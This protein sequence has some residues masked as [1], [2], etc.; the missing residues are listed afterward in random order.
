MTE[1]SGKLQTKPI[2]DP[3]ANPITDPNP[4]YMPLC[5]INYKCITTPLAKSNHIYLFQ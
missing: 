1:K 5:Y 3:N 2:P 4:N